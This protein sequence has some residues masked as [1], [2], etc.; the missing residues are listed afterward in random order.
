MN[1]GGVLTVQAEATG[2]DTQL[3]GIARL[4]ESAQAREAP[5]QQL[6][7]RIAGPFAYTVRA[8]A[9]GSEAAGASG[10]F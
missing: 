7:D 6:A 8:G 9:E 1:W 3:A 4:V 10:R 2:S 5:V